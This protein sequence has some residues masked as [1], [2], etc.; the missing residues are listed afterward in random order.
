MPKTLER[1]VRKNIPSKVVQRE[2]AMLQLI[3][4]TGQISR[5]DLAKHTGSSLG[6]LTGIAN[7]LIGSGIVVESGSGSTPLGRKPVLLQVRDDLAYF[8]GVDLGTYFFRVAVTDMNGHIL[9][10]SELKTELH[11][12]RARVLKR[13]FQYIH[14]AMEAVKISKR[15]IRGIGIGHSAVVDTA[16]GMVLSVPRPGQL[17][18]WKSVPLR[19]MIEKEFGLPCSLHDSVRAIAIAERYFGLGKSLDD[20][21]YIDGGMGFGAGIF[22]GG[23]LYRGAG[24]GA[25]EFGHLTVEDRG[26]LCCCG[27]SGCLEAVATC[28]AI[29]Q[30]AKSAISMGVNSRISE[31]VHGKLD[32][33]SL[34]II[35]QA[36]RENDSLAFRVLNE[37]I[38]YISIALSDLINLLNPKTIV[39]G[40]ALF[41]A[42]PELLVEPLT[43]LIKQRALEKSAN[44]VKFKVSTLGSEAG[45]LG[46]ARLISEQVLEN[47]FFAKK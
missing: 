6:S 11:E 41:R 15:Q 19:E 24:G 28:A 35:A 43:R 27:N 33:V 32:Q 25:G 16:S 31:L 10:K 29:I 17:L 14:E 30:A 46:A 12:G 38:S 7:R 22:I 5:V 45:A 4:S 26:P 40:G 8:V 9:F 42:A 18:E 36:A 20:F 2:F 44:E 34:E 23:E 39:F 13:T 47:I 37:A 1:K 3:H 21:I